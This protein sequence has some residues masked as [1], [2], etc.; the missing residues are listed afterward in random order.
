MTKW[1]PAE[2]AAGRT[3]ASAAGSSSWRVGTTV[4]TFLFFAVGMMAP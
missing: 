2:D 1:T 3:Q 4:V